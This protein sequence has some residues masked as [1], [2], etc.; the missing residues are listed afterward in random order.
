MRALVCQKY[1]TD[2]GIQLAADVYF[3]DGPGPFPV[4]LT[5]TPYDRVGHLAGNARQFVE[6]G[7]A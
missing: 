1:P 7:Y 6:R 4:I 5:R 2:D 3:P